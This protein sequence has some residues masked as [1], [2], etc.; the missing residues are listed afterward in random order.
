MPPAPDAQIRSTD[1][2]ATTD[3]A[4]G[5]TPGVSSA[6]PGGRPASRRRSAGPTLTI[7]CWRDIPAQ[8]TARDG[9]RTQKWELHRRFQVAIDRAAVIAGLETYDRYIAEW[10]SDARP[11]GPDLAAEVAA[12]VKRLE[13]AHPRDLLDS[14]VQNGG[15]TVAPAQEPDPA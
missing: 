6:A 9:E 4:T 5:E 10:R 11:C 2:M 14:L 1:L 7:I 8:V 12:E 13:G 3:P 15:L